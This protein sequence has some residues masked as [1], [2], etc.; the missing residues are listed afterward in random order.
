MAA[1]KTKLL[2]AVFQPMS[3]TWVSLKLRTTALETQAQRANSVEKRRCRDVTGLLSYAE[4]RL[5][6]L[7]GNDEEPE[8]DTSEAKSTSSR[9]PQTV[10]LSA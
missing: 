8:N 2:Q 7:P 9:S 10:Q 6:S 1:T 3:A 4:T 5:L